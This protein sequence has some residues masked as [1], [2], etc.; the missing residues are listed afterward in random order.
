VTGEDGLQA[1]SVAHRL[2][3]QMRIVAPPVHA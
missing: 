3:Q 2:L 1:L